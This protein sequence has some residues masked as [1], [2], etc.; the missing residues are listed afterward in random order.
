[1]LHKAADLDQ[2]AELENTLAYYGIINANILNKIKNFES[3]DP[4]DY[5]LVYNK[6][7]KYE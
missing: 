4:G 2:F 5:V 1:M 7:F 6:F 3:D